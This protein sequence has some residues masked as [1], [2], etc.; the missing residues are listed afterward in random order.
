M[1]DYEKMYLHLVQETDRAINM[2]LKAR[3]E[4]QKMA[5]QEEDAPLPSGKEQIPPS[6]SPR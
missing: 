1:P 2:I 3:Q 5:S 6:G 4:C